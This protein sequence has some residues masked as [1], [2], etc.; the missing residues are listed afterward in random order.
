MQSTLALPAVNIIPFWENRCPSFEEIRQLVNQYFIV[1]LSG[2]Y[3]YGIVLE[4]SPNG[5]INKSII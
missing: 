2:G 5:K 4:L 1:R 3:T